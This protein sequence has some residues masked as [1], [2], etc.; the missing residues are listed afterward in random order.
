M[1]QTNTL[2][3]ASGPPREQ[4]DPVELLARLPSPESLSGVLNRALAV[5]PALRQRGVAESPG[6][7]V[8]SGRGVRA[9]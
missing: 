1:W 9:C 8:Q 4:R 7:A 6:M 5:L 2:V 3:A